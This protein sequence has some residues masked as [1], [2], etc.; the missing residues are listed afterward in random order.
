MKHE[1]HL[2]S[3]WILASLLL[4]VAAGAQARPCGELVM[5]GTHDGTSTRYALAHPAGPAQGRRVAL[6][7]LVGGGGH[8]RLDDQACPQALTGN[9][10]VRSLPLF[11]EAGFS[12]ALVDA[13]SDHP[14]EDGLAGFRASA[15]HAQDLGRII[16]DV[17]KR[18]RASDL[19]DRHQSR[20][21]LGGQRGEP[22]ERPC[23]PRWPGADLA[24]HLG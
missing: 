22:P 10:L 4:L 18:T 17:R 21:D 23:G 6:V 5:I 20:R 13:P 19:A 14:G 8:L 9:S 3:V 24:G 11:H 15:T 7:L 2:R 12:T 1:G 16:A